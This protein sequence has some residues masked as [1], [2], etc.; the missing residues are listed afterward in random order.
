[1]RLA[2][3]KL[4]GF[5]SYVEPTTIDL[6]HNLTV[7]VGP[8]GC[9][10]SNVVDAFR[11]VIGESQ[12]RQLRGEDLESM[13]F[14]GSDTRAP[15][16]RASVELL[17]DNEDFRIK[18]PFAQYS[19]ISLKREL[20]RDAP[21][22]FYLNGKRCRRKDIRDLVL[23]AG[24]SARGYAVIPQGLIAQLVISKPEELRTHIEDAA[25]VSKYRDRRRDTEKKIQSA[26]QNL[27]RVKDHAEELQRQ[28]SHLQR[29]SREAARF[30]Q[31]KDKERLLKAKL[32]ALEMQTLN[33]ESDTY[34]ERVD[35]LN[36]ALQHEQE[37][38]ATKSSEIAARRTQET[39]LS[40]Q[41]N[42]VQ[43]Q[44]YQARAHLSRLEESIASQE[45]RH[46]ELK[47]EQEL[48]ENRI[49]TDRQ[50]I[51]TTERELT[52]L[53]GRHQD[54][55]GKRDQ[56]KQ[57]VLETKTDFE[58]TKTQNVREKKEWD[59]IV[60]NYNTTERDNELQNA[61]L[62]R[63]HDEIKR[64]EEEFERLEPDTQLTLKSSEVDLL[65]TE[66][67]QLQ[68][69][70][71]DRA[72]KLKQLHEKLTRLEQNEGKNESER[73][74]LQTNLYNLG[75]K[76]SALKTIV[77]NGLGLDTTAV[78]ERTDLD[79]ELK[80][81]PRLG[82]Q[83]EVLPGWERAVE[84]LLASSM[85]AFVVPSL[86]IGLSKMD[87]D[88]ADGIALV[89]STESTNKRNASLGSVIHQGNELIAAIHRN[90]LITDTLDEALEIRNS[91]NGDATVLTKSAII[92][93]KHWIKL[94]DTLLN[95]N[96]ILEC[97]TQLDEVTNKFQECETSLQEILQEISQQK[98]DMAEFRDTSRNLQEEVTRFQDTISKRRVEL[99]RAQNKHLDRVKQRTEAIERR[100]RLQELIASVTSQLTQTQ[101]DIV[102][103]GQELNQLEKKRSHLAARQQELDDLLNEALQNERAAREHF[104]SLDSSCIEMN[105]NID[106]LVT[107]IQR[108][109]KD[110]TDRLNRINEINN[111]IS[112]GQKTFLEQT[113]QRAQATTSLSE[114]E[115]QL[116][117]VVQ[118]RDELQHIL[119]TC[120]TEEN[121]YRLKAE[122]IQQDLY[123]LRERVVETNS[124]KVYLTA[125]IEK[126]QYEAEQVVA[127]LD[128]EEH[129]EKL[130]SSL[131]RIQARLERLGA[132]NL[133]AQSDLDRMVAEYEA[134]IERVN[135]LQT[136]HA[137]LEEA[138]LKI[139]NESLHL[140]NATLNKANSD[141]QELFK[142]L[143][144][145][146]NAQL[147]L[148]GDDPLTAGVSMQVNP[149]GKQ[150][151]TI[152]QLSDGERA[153]TALA[154]IFAMFRLNP[155]PVCILD[156]VDAPLDEH[157]VY[158]F[159]SL[160]QEMAQEIQFLLISHD[161]V[162]MQ[163]AN[164]LIGV[165]MEESG[166][167][168]FVSVDLETQ[169]TEEVEIIPE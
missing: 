104:Q 13:I 57:K 131:A 120:L 60:Q 108:T 152:S 99:E 69:N 43:G 116:H 33:V 114:I 52:K 113:H 138:M 28:I 126:L 40:D 95:K 168:R 147:R 30:T 117:S 35:E 17:F 121:Q 85:S 29:Q 128:D 84:T 6:P 63:L 20:Y 106:S 82:E 73:E 151:K 42:D 124:K 118:S 10:K 59:E 26:S 146:G 156:E 8:N 89:E 160:I 130:T 111:E 34:Q 94:P 93:G 66:L 4:A 72:N 32:L 14:D 91:L 12:A 110:L 92:L 145:G 150:V 9:G 123:S 23:S 53:Q 136:S 148:T 67:E 88:R 50:D 83:I 158:R 169:L 90:V 98:R 3:I 37:K 125:E 141:F 27:E 45:R 129:E 46:K 54:L 167:S 137:M 65:Q 159:V 18:G 48:L 41:F 87:Y 47:T 77:E 86:K 22:K 102:Q 31:L 140:F 135:D 115:E 139:D 163:H 76:R 55:V 78:E 64:F 142:S 7:I 81:Y 149:P 62:Q 153:L 75:E 79:S 39:E 155:S 119:R 5:K 49:R 38:L 127:L 61:Q 36:S 1:M 112:R 80:K 25:G 51:E 97:R 96:S 15:A 166:V 56:A 133:A 144:G 44:S 134:V 68:V 101:E 164:S 143:F 11:L 2:A 100:T 154:F 107:G 162:T 71:D 109:S 19:E 161:R 24:F 16:G 74:R 122:A 105:A 165:T 58:Q 70:H 132:V 157:N 103:L 21:S